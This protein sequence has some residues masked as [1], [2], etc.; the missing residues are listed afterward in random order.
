MPPSPIYDW[1]K[2][3]LGQEIEVTDWLTVSQAMIDGFA[4]VTGDRQWIHVD[5]DR[6]R[7]DSPFGITVA[8]GFL[9]LSL[10]AGMFELMPEGAGVARGINY[11]VEGL[12]FPAPVPAGAK[13]RGRRTVTD[14]GRLPEGGAKVTSH[15]S[16]EVKGSEKPACVFESIVLLFPEQ[17]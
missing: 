3:R 17:A 9:V 7:R 14:V 5:P 16:I 15:I 12:R 1:Y 4:D 10:A 2:D 8:H 13:I 6:A 11:G